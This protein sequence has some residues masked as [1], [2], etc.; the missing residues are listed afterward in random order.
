[1]E[2][3]ARLRRRGARGA[4]VG[5]RRLL[6]A[7]LLAL[8]AGHGGAAGP[9]GLAPQ[10]EWV[11][12][13]WSSEGRTAG[14]LLEKSASPSRGEVAV[15]V[16]GRELSLVLEKNHKLLSPDYTETHYTKDGQ[17]VT[18]SP[19]RTVSEKLEPAKAMGQGCRTLL[20]PWACPRVPGLLGGAEY[21][22]WNQWPRLRLNSHDVLAVDMMPRIRGGGGVALPCQEKLRPEF[23][24]IHSRTGSD[25]AVLRRWHEGAL[26]GL[27]ALS[28][29]D[30]Y[31]L[32]PPSNPESE[33]HLI[34][35]AEHLPIKGG[36]CGH[37]D[38]LHSHIA[39]MVRV[40]RPAAHQREQDLGRTKQRILEI[41][42]YVDKFYR[43]LNIKVALIGL[44]VWTD[45]DK[46]RVT[47]DAHASLVS[48][49]QWKKSLKMQKK[50]DNAQLLTGVTFK[51]TTIGMA[52]LEG[53]CNAENS[54]G[55]SMDHSPQPIGAAATMAHEIG[56]NFGMSHDV[57][58]CCV[59]ATASEGGCVM[60]A[61]T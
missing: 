55:V 24:L 16:E 35:R 21:L 56:H 57:E 59:E 41:A 17:A 10:G 37:G 60:A 61:A 53:M 32:E 33:P 2:R 26:C 23:P 54:G 12:P 22:L 47:S 45:R 4:P 6:L 3:G 43:S 27:I 46:C 5:G 48:F 9:R 30:S 58:G 34:Y 31:Y 42:N 36:T 40:F 25:H 15:T 7:L 18:I 50:H 49:L 51:G 8:F 1:M 19:N 52:P 39:D 14:G 28:H 44:E 11:R 38:Q 13:R 20:L 29:N